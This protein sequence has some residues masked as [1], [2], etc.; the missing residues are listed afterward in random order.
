MKII[1]ILIGVIIIMNNARATTKVLHPGEDDPR[2]LEKL[3]IE[4]ARV[5]SGGKNIGVHS[6][7]VSYGKYGVTMI[8]VR[9]LQRVGI[10]DNN[11]RE[12]WLKL[13]EQNEYIARLYLQEMYRR[14]KSWYLAV[15][16]YHGGDKRARV[17]YAERVYE[18]FYNKGTTR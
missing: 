17:R 9:E 13:P 10:V 14:H 18:S 4:I 7:G 1:L 12:S 3:L 5:E 2:M 8:A 11:F 15:G 6:D 16:Y